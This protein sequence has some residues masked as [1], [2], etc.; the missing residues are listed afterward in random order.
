MLAITICYAAAGS[1]TVLGVMPPPSALP[2][3]PS[4]SAA[5]TST[6]AAAQPITAAAVQPTL[7]GAAQTTPSVVVPTGL[8]LG[9]GLLP[10]PQKLMRRII[11]LEFVEMRELL[12]EEWLHSV[13]EESDNHSCCNSAVKKKKAPVTNIFTWFQGYASLV[14]ALSTAY[15]SKVPQFMAYQ[16]MIIRC[17]KDFEGLAWV[18]YDHAFHR[19]A[20]VSKNLDWSQ[21][22]TT[23]YSLCFAGRAKR[24]SICAHCLS[25]NHTSE[26]CPEA[27]SAPASTPAR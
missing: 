21:V 27:P 7:L 26:N 4:F 24:S 19:Q 8:F 17:Y 3:L 14:G 20:A 22:N 23:L 12:P 9:D 15:P 13:T 2:L 25:D 11:A 6:S 1:A 5:S 18:Q 16:S 10:L